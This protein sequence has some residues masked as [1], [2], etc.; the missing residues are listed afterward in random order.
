MGLIIWWCG[1]GPIMVYHFNV[2][3]KYWWLYFKWEIVDGYNF[4]RCMT[5][6]R[7]SLY[8]NNTSG[9]QT[10]WWIYLALNWSLA[11]YT[12]INHLILLYSVFQESIGCIWK[13]QGHSSY[14]VQ[15]LVLIKIPLRFQYQHVICQYY[16][17]S[18][19]A[20]WHKFCV[21]HLLFISSRIFISKDGHTVP[22]QFLI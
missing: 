19:L 10:L 22:R 7:Y 6:L 15:G 2:F 18:L 12:D 9:L 11:T 5:C 21:I 3:G 20:R 4:S 8:W 1:R 17:V 13:K 14:L 16:C